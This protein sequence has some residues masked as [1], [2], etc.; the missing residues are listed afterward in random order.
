MRATPVVPGTDHPALA[1]TAVMC[2][3]CGAQLAADWRHCP[4]CGLALVAR[5]RPPLLRR[6]WWRVLLVGTV[7]YFATMKLLA[8]SGNPNFA[9]TVILLGAFLI[10]VAYL[11]YLY[12]SNALED[13][14]L[15]TLALTFFYGGVLGI[16]VAQVLEQRL[17]LSSGWG[18]L[19]VGFSEE[20]AKPLG[21]L[22]LARRDEYLTPRHGFFL[23][24]A[25]GMGFAAFET[26][27]YGFTFLIG[28][29]GNLDL[30]G[31][32]LLTRGLLSP[33]GHAAW[34]ALV[35]GVFWREGRRINRAVLG[36]FL[37]AVLLHTLWNYTAGLIPIEIALPGVELR[38]RFVDLS[39]PELSLPVPSLIVGA[40]GLWIVRRA[41][42][43]P[44]AAPGA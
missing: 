16:I 41:S 29:K 3:R 6:N 4:A 19:A 34:T 40:L 31:E 15:S 32:V 1:A 2:R 11:T 44:A 9:P 25:A 30:L 20:I 5:E 24:A 39:I 21:A 38:W 37:T 14:P 8:S 27:G 18:M 12:E 36:A 10:P 35:V 33:M 26:M 17:V 13:V 7:L 23:G 28:S 42:R 43:T 22:W